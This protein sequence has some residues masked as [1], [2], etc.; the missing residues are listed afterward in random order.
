MYEVT[1]NS[2]QH[3]VKTPHGYKTPHRYPATGINYTQLFEDLNWKLYPTG[4]AWYMKKGGVFDRIHKAIDR[5]FIRL[6][7]DGRYTLDSV[8]PDNENFDINDCRLWEYRLGL[9]TNETLSVSVR[10][11]AIRRK[12]AYPNNVKARQ[13][14][15][16]IQ[17]QLQSAGFNVWIHENKFFEG[18]EWVY[19]TPAQITSTSITVTQHGGDT[20]HGGGTQHG[21]TGFDVIANQARPNESFSVNDESLWATFFIGGEILGDAAIVPE[22]RQIEF[23]EL[24]LKLKPAHT[25]VFTFIAY[26]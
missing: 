20:Q 1:E 2:T 21:F 13:H 12:I 24:V 3:G 16:F 11:E 6:L 15:L 25:V 17:S 23:R 22:S 8:F 19:K 5:S 18:G 14:P 10:R 26:A 4:R 7:E 9:I